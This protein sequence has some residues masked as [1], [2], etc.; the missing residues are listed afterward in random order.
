MRTKCN[1]RATECVGWVEAYLGN[2]PSIPLGLRR[3]ESDCNLPNSETQRFYNLRTT[4]KRRMD[5]GV[6]NTKPLPCPLLLFIDSIVVLLELTG[7]LPGR[8]K[9]VRF[10]FI[11]NNYQTISTYESLTEYFVWFTITAQ[12]NLQ[13]LAPSRPFFYRL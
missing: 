3:V 8:F 13:K 2:M 4:K 11:I 5:W 12:P 9:C 1:Q 6:P 7:L 10:R